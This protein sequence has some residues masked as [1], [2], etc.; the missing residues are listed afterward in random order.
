[1]SAPD[2]SS[3]LERQASEIARRREELLARLAHDAP[4]DPGRAAEACRALGELTDELHLAH[5][6]LAQERF[7]TVSSIDR[8]LSELRDAATIDELLARA[9]AVAC[10]CCGFDRVLIARL[11]G[12]SSWLPSAVHPGTPENT[13]AP[14]ELDRSL[15]E[16]DLRRRH[17]AALVR[18]PGPAERLHGRLTGGDGERSFVATPLGRT[19]ATLGFLY[20][21]RHASGPVT[22][23]DRDHLWLFG[24]GLLL[25][26]ESLLLQD[27]LAEQR[28]RALRAFADTQSLID[29][30]CDSR[31][32]LDERR[33]QATRLVPRPTHRVDLLFTAREREVLRLMVAGARNQEMADQL[34]LAEST[35]KTHTARILRKLRA[36]TRAEAVSRYLQIA[37]P[38]GR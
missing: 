12:S 25:V 31:V 21:D 3:G 29:E 1:M 24:E 33:R 37:R 4:A 15:L 22:L 16:A 38:A 34:V 7:A 17:V 10:E 8:S 6:R 11:E 27:R 9:A 2:G 5:D 23:A 18:D 19:E 30:L 20:G 13:L 26:Y 32:S 14:A 28:E 35:V 36:S